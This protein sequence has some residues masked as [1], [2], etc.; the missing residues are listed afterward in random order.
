MYVF[1]EVDSG[2]GNAREC[3]RATTADRINCLG[4]E[5]KADRWTGLDCQLEPDH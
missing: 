3:F 4:R 1:E 2:G 5:S